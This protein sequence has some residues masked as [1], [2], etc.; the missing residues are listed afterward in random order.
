MQGMEV[1]RNAFQF[2]PLREG[3]RCLNFRSRLPISFQFTPLREGRRRSGTERDGTAYYFNSRPSARGDEAALSAM[4]QRIISIHAPPR[5]ATRLGKR[6]FFRAYFNSRPSARGDRVYPRYV[7]NPKQFQFTPLREGRQGV[8]ECRNWLS[9]FQFTPLREGRRCAMMRPARMKH[10]NSRP[11]ARGDVRVSAGSPLLRYFNSR[12]SARGDPEVRHQYTARPISIHAPPR[13]ATGAVGDIAF[14]DA[15]QFTPLRE[16]RHRWIRVRHMMQVISIHAPPRG[17]TNSADDAAS[18]GYFNSRPSARGDVGGGHVDATPF[19]FNSRPSARG[20]TA[21]RTERTIDTHF[22]SR[23]SAR[24]DQQC[25]ERRI[26]SGNISIHAPP[27]GATDMSVWI[28]Q[29]D[30]I[31]IHAPPR[32]ATSLSVPVFACPIFQ[33]TPLREGRRRWYTL[34]HADR[35]F[36]SRPSARGDAS[37]Q[38][39]A[40]W[41]VISIHAPPR[42]ATVGQSR[43]SSSNQFQFTPLREGRRRRRMRHTADAYFNSRP[44]ARGDGRRYR[45][46]G[47]RYLISIHAPPRGATRR[48]NTRFAVLPISIHAP[49]RGATRSKISALRWLRISIHAPPRGATE[50]NRRLCAGVR[51]QFTPL[52]EGRLYRLLKDNRIIISIHAPPRG[53]TFLRHRLY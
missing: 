15:F 19:Y 39:S 13:G 27:R 47:R 20:D 37:G 9:Q 31:S 23:P 41:D 17:A 2:T 46:R 22:N 7:L 29:S 45:I 49:P 35:H 42:G 21:A 6:G 43:G 52:R 5:G 11:S 16:G 33:F 48:R 38:R 8:G 25:L 50:R 28:E 34:S 51:F 18:R 36:N 32:G 14:L 53:A 30:T 40:I 10:F 24:G 1:C 4:E 3:R 44:S 26:R 12:P